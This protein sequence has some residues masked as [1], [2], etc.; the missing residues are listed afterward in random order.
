MKPVLTREQ[1]RTFDRIA[2]D[3]FSM[4]GILLMENAARGLA[5]ALQAELVRRRQTIARLVILC[6]PGNN[7]GDGYAMA[8]HLQA[9]GHDVAC[10]RVEG[11]PPSADATCNRHLWERLAGIETPVFNNARADEFLAATQNADWI[12]DALFG[13]GLTRPLDGAV[14]T[15]IEAVNR[16]GT[17]VFAVDLPSGLDANTGLPVGGAEHSEHCI[18][19]T[20]TGTLGAWKVGLLTPAAHGVVGAVDC[21]NLGIAEELVLAEIQRGQSGQ[22]IARLLDVQQARAINAALPARGA[23]HHKHRSGELAILGGS[24]G[25]EGAAE[26]CGRA[27]LRTGAGLVRL[28]FL[29][30]ESSTPAIAHDHPS[31]STTPELMRQSLSA[32]AEVGQGPV[33]KDGKIGKAAAFVLG[34]GLG[35]NDHAA[36]LVQASLTWPHLPRVY[37]ADALTHLVPHLDALRATARQCSAGA[38]LVP[39]IL[40]PHSG[41]AARLLR[42]SSRAIESDRWGAAQQLAEETACIVVLKGAHTLIAYSDPQNGLCQWVSPISCPALAVSGSGDVL[43]GI[44]GALLLELPPLA[45]TQLGVWL[46]GQAG[47]CWSGASAPGACQHQHSRVRGLLAQ[48]IAEQVPELLADLSHQSPL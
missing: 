46:H 12:V 26:L 15:L 39:P 10:W 27:A 47:L 30:Q 32:E 7:G 17:P 20:R 31:V 14:K 45:A 3:E 37:D 36:L 8:R 19:A 23:V 48:E 43:A 4:P 28:H 11:A 2:I 6:G 9:L 16:S 42:T 40:T 21:I 5:D 29:R 1:M 33:G 34:P 35:L 22:P 38:A 25:M 24:T 13:T 44:I 18:H 41:E